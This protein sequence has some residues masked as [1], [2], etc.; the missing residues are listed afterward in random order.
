MREAS[1]I[2]V[3]RR[4]YHRFHEKTIAETAASSGANGLRATI[5]HIDK[6]GNIVTNLRREDLRGDFTIHLDGSVHQ[7]TLLETF[8]EAKPGEL[9]AIEGS[10]G[11]I[12][13]ALN[14]GS[15]AERLAIA[16]GT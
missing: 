13:I 10:A 5:L 14:Q 12:E 3:G 9:L 1:P 7:T 11:Y 2:E 15:A 16:R 8:A 6:F 4:P